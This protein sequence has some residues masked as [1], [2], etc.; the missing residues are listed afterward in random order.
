MIY[1][2]VNKWY[3]I[4][5]K[6]AA[7]TRTK[8][9]VHVEVFLLAGAKVH[10]HNFLC[11]ILC[12]RVLFCLLKVFY[13]FK[14]TSIHLFIFLFFCTSCLLHIVPYQASNWNVWWQNFSL[15]HWETSEQWEYRT[16][17]QLSASERVTGPLVCCVLP[18]VCERPHQYWRHHF[19]L[20]HVHRKTKW[21]P[22][23]R[24]S[25]QYW[26]WE[27]SQRIGKDFQGFSSQRRNLHKHLATVSYICT[28]DSSPLNCTLILL[29][30][31]TNV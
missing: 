12:F 20:P 28:F 1:V 10:C 27:R 24:V 15:W 5:H 8:K 9:C 11:F 4:L 13:C 30:Y 2:I 31:L 26:I 21:V 6:P 18:V 14:L 19:I 16:D 25:C 7:L 22:S 3:I 17:I 23:T 29:Y